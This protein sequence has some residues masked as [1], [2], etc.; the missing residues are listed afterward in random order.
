MKML[1]RSTYNLSNSDSRNRQI[2]IQFIWIKEGIKNHAY[3]L[4]IVSTKAKLRK[5]EMV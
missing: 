3:S 1:S 5:N 4:M 2:K